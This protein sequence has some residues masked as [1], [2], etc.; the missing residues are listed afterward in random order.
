[1]I[2]APA[3]RELY[4]SAF[5]VYAF[6]IEHLD[7]H[8]WR[9]MK[10]E[11]VMLGCRIDKDTAVRAMRTLVRRQYLARRGGGPVGYEYRLLPPPLPL[12]KARAA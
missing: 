11:V 9:R 8:D 1:M 2:P 7:R 5:K 3:Y 12:V 4:P 6:A 10:L